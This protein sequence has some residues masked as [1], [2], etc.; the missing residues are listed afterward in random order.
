M[1]LN[2]YYHNL[3]SFREMDV[4]IK[5]LYQMKYMDFKI[6]GGRGINKDFQI[7][8]NKIYILLILFF[9]CVIF[10][11][12][13]FNIDPDNTLRAKNVISIKKDIV[14]TSNGGSEKKF[15]TLPERIRTDKPFSIK[16]VLAKYDYEGKAI[17]VMTNYTDYDISIDGVVFY[18]SESPKIT[19]PKSNGGQIYTVISLPKKIKNPIMTI[20]YYP[21]LNFETKYSIE[22]I[23]IGNRDD[24]FVYMV[25]KDFIVLS[26]VFLMFMLFLVSM[27][28]SIA[29]Y[30]SGVFE[31]SIFYVGMSLLL[32]GMYFLTKTKTLIYLLSD[33]RA[34]IYFLDYGPFMFM[35]YPVLKLIQ[36]KIRPIF[37]KIVGVAVRILEFTYLVELILTVTRFSDF[38]DLLSSNLIFNFFYGL[39]VVVSLIFSIDTKNKETILLSLSI[40]PLFANLAVGITAFN[41]IN[42]INLTSILIVNTLI[43]VILQIYMFTKSYQKIREE[44][45]KSEV[46]REM[47]ELDALTSVNNRYSFEQKIKQIKEKP[48]KYVIITADLNNLKMINDF[49]GHD[50][51]DNAIKGVSSHLKENLPS[52][53]VY[54][55][56]GDEFMVICDGNYDTSIIDNIK[57]IVNVPTVSDK[58][59]ITFSIGYEIYNPKGELSLE[60]VIKISDKNMYTDKQKMKKKKNRR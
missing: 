27:V 6:R 11:K 47:M 46:Y 45:T 59:E 13:Y 7:F 1:F 56:G 50:A 8:L 21:K 55:T 60:E 30:A 17:G 34:I 40:I 54:R 9:V 38:K 31:N 26:L 14:L 15:I 29:S 53:T 48:K 25:E 49:I 16:V 43:F 32:N 44:N 36:H 41:T 10:P 52:S 42:T 3:E 57:K 2:L 12:L 4:K 23:D 58:I 33:K 18:K 35:I 22:A 20:N 37:S 24:F 5:K 51:G 39:L 28:I 19:M